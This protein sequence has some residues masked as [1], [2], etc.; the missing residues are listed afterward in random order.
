MF[1]SQHA[2]YVHHCITVSFTFLLMKSNITKL[3]LQMLKKNYDKG[4]LKDKK[5][6]TNTY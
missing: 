2:A 3:G 5:K 1:N 6:T 4:L